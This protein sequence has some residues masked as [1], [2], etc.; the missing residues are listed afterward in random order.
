M[1]FYTLWYNRTLQPPYI[2]RHP[3]LPVPRSQDLIFLQQTIDNALIAHLHSKEGRDIQGPPPEIQTSYSDYPAPIT[4]MFNGVSFMFLIGSYYITLSPF[5]TLMNMMQEISR[6]KEYRLR[7]GLN[8]IGVTHSVYW[9]HWIIIG[10]L[11][12]VA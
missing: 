5:L 10:F 7:Q 2:L 3:A 9:L 4:R 6:E 12:N 8:V 1:Y 11:I